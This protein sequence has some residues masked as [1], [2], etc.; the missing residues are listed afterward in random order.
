MQS[1]FERTAMKINQTPFDRAL[2]GVIGIAL[3]ASPVMGLDTI[4]VNW[5]G[6]I[7]WA[8]AVLGWCPL[9]AAFGITTCT[10]SSY[11]HLREGIALHERNER[12]AARV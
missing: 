7:P 4:P 5:I 2:R 8:T 10:P 3:V 12:H 9:Y 1:A 6:L 11:L